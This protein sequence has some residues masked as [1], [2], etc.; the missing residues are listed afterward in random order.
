MTRLRA[1][2]WLAVTTALAL[3][4]VAYRVDATVAVPAG[5]VEALR[6]EAQGPPDGWI[7][8]DK[9]QEWSIVLVMQYAA[10]GQRERVLFF[11]KRETLQELLLDV[12][13]SERTRKLLHEVD[14]GRHAG[15]GV[16]AVEQQQEGY[17]SFDTNPY[18]MPILGSRREEFDDGIPTREEIGD[19]DWSDPDSTLPDHDGDGIPDHLDRDSDNDGW[20]DADEGTGDYDC[21]G[22]P[23]YVDRDSEDGDCYGGGDR[24]MG[25]APRVDE[26][27]AA[28][29][30]PLPLLGLSRRRRR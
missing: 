14:A 4:V 8:D 25:C 18:L 3:L 11:E 24:N 22:L 12:D 7:A 6:V 17:V 26:G 21:D 16:I 23:D 9:V 5:T 29:L 13:V 1:R 10:P 30:L 15:T 19:Y 2:H 28:L 20:L 27:V